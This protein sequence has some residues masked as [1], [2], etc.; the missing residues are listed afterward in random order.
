MEE[1]V[2]RIAATQYG[3]VTRAQL[4]QAGLTKSEI[5]GRV[6]KGM[7]AAV[8][9]GIYRVGHRAP[10]LKATYLAAVLACGSGALLGGRAAGHLY[11]LLKG[12]PPPPE[13]I[14]PTHRKVSGIR[15]RRCRHLDRR[16][17]TVF[18]CIPLTTVPRTLVDLSAVLTSDALARACHEA[19]VR[20]RASPRHVE[21]VLE[22]RP[23]SPGAAN[24]R[25]VLRGDVQVSSSRLERYFLTLLRDAGLELPRTNCLAGG[26][27]VDCRWPEQRL[28]VELD[29]YRYHQSRPWELDR[30][31]EREAHARGDEFR[32]Y[33]YGDV[34]EHPR[35]ML[36][37]LRA[38]LP[39]T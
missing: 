22:R 17:A 20:H 31:R 36:R 10:S 8:H 11:G 25:R 9:R 29:S 4:L 18:R 13:V 30:R 5:D 21:A 16:D 14:T 19:G 34:F 38:L 35:L 23:N 26:R 1:V 39:P 3:V 2:G 32:R 12:S 37:E 7:L 24:L 6:S 15:S 28:T 27:R 33:T